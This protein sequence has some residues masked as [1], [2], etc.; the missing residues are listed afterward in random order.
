MRSSITVGF[1][2]PKSKFAIFGNLIRVYQGTDYSHTYIKFPDIQLISQAS[3]GMVNFMAVPVFNEHNS[4]VKEF[5]FPT[6]EVQFIKIKRYAMKTAGKKYSILQVF[7]IVFADLFKLKKNPFDTDKETFVCSEY[8]GEILNI[9]EISVD[10]DL[11]LVTPED[12]YK[13]MEKSHVDK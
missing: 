13:I 11:S 12:I 7:G 9:L 1:S 6:S 3:K 10:K 4:V 8:I 2:K 5:S